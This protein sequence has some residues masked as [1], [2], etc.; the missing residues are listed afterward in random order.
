[1]NKQ[2]PKPDTIVIERVLAASPSQAFGA[3]ANVEERKLWDVPGESW[4]IAEM[5][6]DFREDGIERSRFGPP[7]HPIAESFGR[8]QVIVEDTRIVS[9]GV[10]RALD[11]GSVSSVTMLTVNF[12]A[13][14]GGT[15]L[16]LIDQSVYLGDGEIAE[17]RRSGWESI[18]EKLDGYLE[19]DEDQRDVDAVSVPSGGS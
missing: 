18:V 11:E 19:R 10:M 8:Y 14:Q 3:W 17:M 9:S 1:M 7:G 15:K 13:T 12:E 16:T 2:T 6:Q 5:E 4:V